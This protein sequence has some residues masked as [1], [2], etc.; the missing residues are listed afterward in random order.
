[1]PKI[2]SQEGVLGIRRKKAIISCELEGIMK[3]FIEYE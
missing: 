2:V 3:R 1:L